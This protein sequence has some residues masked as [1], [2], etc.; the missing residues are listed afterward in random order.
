MKKRDL[1]GSAMMTLVTVF[2]AAQLLG[3]GDPAPAPA[4]SSTEALAALSAC[5]LDDGTIETDAHLGGCD[6]GD[7][8]KTTICH[9]PPG[10]PANAHTICV[11]N[12]AVPHHVK[13]HGDLVG[14]CRT[15]TSCPTPPSGMGGM[16]GGG[17]KPDPTCPQGQA[18]CGADPAACPAEVGTCTNGCCVA[19]IPL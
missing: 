6:A 19:W 3:C 17:G 7:A 5:G 15:E 2:G 14:P 10:N 12:P 1:L 18:A 9:I 4:A 16:K 13:N 8:K 11:G